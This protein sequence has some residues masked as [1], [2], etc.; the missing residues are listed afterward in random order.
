MK[1]RDVS[2]ML[3]Q[4]GK[5][6]LYANIVFKVKG[7]V[8]DREACSPDGDYTKAGGRIS[9]A[10]RKRKA[11]EIQKIIESVDFGGDKEETNEHG[12]DQENS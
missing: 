6:E 12:Q 4:S 3:A 5:N 11:K 7:H 2:V 10:S 9:E 8:L 1:P